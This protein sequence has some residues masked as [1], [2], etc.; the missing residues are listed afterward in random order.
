MNKPRF[1]LPSDTKEIVWI[2]NQLKQNYNYKNKDIAKALE[3]TDAIVSN[4]L[5]GRVKISQKYIDKLEE[6]LPQVWQPALIRVSPP[7]ETG[8]GIYMAVANIYDPFYTWIGQGTCHPAVKEDYETILQECE[9]WVEKK[10][11][12]IDIVKKYIDAEDYW[13]HGI[14]DEWLYRAGEAQGENA[15]VTFIRPEGPVTKK[16][17]VWQ[18]K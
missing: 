13:Q 1:Y 9:S 5:T 10:I 7:D 17:I 8:I 4:W 15:Q 2:L 16:A 12:T 14:E 3:T 6:F 18:K 11:S